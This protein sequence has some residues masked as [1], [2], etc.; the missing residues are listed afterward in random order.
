MI[1]KSN[2]I[3]YS[4]GNNDE[5]HTPSYAVTPIIEYIPKDAI[6]WCPFDTSKSSFVKDIG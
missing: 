3:L 4:N 2:E 1:M 5:C 6:V